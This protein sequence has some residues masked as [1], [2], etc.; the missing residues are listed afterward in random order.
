MSVSLEQ[1]VPPPAIAQQQEATKDT[2][3]ISVIGRSAVPRTVKESP[4]PV[5]IVTAEEFNGVG[6]AG[7]VTDNLKG[8]SFPLIQRHQPP[9]MAVHSSVLPRYVVCH[10]TKP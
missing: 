1:Y 2:E 7:D 9:V 6:N 4:V 8:S 5:D 10:P 3:V